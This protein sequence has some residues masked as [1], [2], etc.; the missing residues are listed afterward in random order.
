MR[1]AGALVLIAWM[2][3]CG[4]SSR[5]GG[6]DDGGG[7]LTPDAGSG[8]GGGGGGGGEQVFVYAHTAKT[9]YKVD[10]D[11]LQVQKVADFGWGSV[12]SDDMTDIAIDKNGTMIGVSFTRVYRI[13]PSNAATTMLSSGLTRSFN[14]LSFV[15]ADQLGQTGD[16]VL[17]GTQNLDGKVFKIDQNTGAATEVGN[18][19]ATFVSSGD[20]VG[21]AGFGTVQTV[22]GSSGDTLAR[23]APS[24]FGASAIGGGT[25]FSKVWGVAYFKGKIYGFTEGGLFVLIDPG[26]GAGTMVS[27]SGI[28]WWGAAVTTVAPV[29]Q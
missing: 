20:L 13:D 6:D 8:G 15:P 16:D 1:I 7:G 21:I 28:A 26:T 18:M 25:G 14:G 4:P 9:L 29:L 19:G 11:T 27:N 3:A 10:P 23:L 17:V 22:P 12:V 24:T 2:I 5:S